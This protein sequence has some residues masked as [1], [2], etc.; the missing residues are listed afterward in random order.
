MINLNEVQYFV[1][2]TLKKAQQYGDLD[3]PK[4]KLYGNKLDL[5]LAG[6]HVCKFGDDADEIYEM[7]ISQKEVL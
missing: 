3:Y 4:L 1:Y 2:T 5:Q 7:L 6:G